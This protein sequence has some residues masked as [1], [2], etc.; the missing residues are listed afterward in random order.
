MN[1]AEAY[2]AK[3]NA[4]DA[5][6]SALQAYIAAAEANGMDDDEQSGEIEGLLAD[7]GKKWDVLP[8]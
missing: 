8:Q 1:E 2:T 4:R 3:E 7:A 6:L 5:L